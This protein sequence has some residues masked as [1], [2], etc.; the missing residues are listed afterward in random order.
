MI[1]RFAASK[2][3]TAIS[4]TATIPLMTALQNRARIGEIGEYCKAM[5]ASRLI[6]MIA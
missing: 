6:V 1:E 2:P 4:G 3:I 5:A